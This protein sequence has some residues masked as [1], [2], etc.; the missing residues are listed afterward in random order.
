MRWVAL[1]GPCAIGADE[2]RQIAD[3]EQLRTTTI[4]A[5]T[6]TYGTDDIHAVRLY[7]V[8]PTHSAITPLRSSQI[9]DEMTTALFERGCASMPGLTRRPTSAS[10][11]VMRPTTAPSTKRRSRAGRFV[12]TAIGRGGYDFRTAA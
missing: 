12:C 2:A 8:R 4:E 9:T 5:F 3:Q 10:R 1:Y 7:E 6:H 11:L